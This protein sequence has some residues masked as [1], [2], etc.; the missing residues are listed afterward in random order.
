MPTTSTASLL[1]GS[2][3]AADKTASIMPVISCAV[4]PLARSATRNPARTAGSTSSS[5][6]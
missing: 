2:G 3:A 4:S 1:S 6:T 5:M